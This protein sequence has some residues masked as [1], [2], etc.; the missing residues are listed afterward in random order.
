M[1]VNEMHLTSDLCREESVKYG[2]FVV[3]KSQKV[4]LLTGRKAFSF[5]DAYLESGYHKICCLQ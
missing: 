3:N 1:Y 2:C 4:C 5:L